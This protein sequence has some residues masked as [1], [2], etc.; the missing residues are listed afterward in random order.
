[1][2]EALMK[3]LVFNLVGNEKAAS[4]EGKRLLGKI[5]ACGSVRLGDD[6]HAA[7]ILV[8]FHAA[9]DESEER[10]IAADADAGAGAEF[11]AALADEDVAGNYGL[12]AELFH[13]EALTA[14]IPSVF[15][16]ALS[17]LMSHE[18]GGWVVAEI[19]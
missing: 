4:G 3:R 11:R 12:I 16:R 10:V 1:M 19:S 6:V 13:A 7:G 5:L 18:S 15:D 9:I 14:G 8:E 17:F 2:E